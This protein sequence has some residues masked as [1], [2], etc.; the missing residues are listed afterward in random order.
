MRSMSWILRFSVFRMK[1][2]ARW[3][4]LSRTKEHTMVLSGSV[5]DCAT[6]NHPHGGFRP[7]PF[8]NNW[9]KSFLHLSSTISDKSTHFTSP[10]QLTAHL[11]FHMIPARLLVYRSNTGPY[12][13][14]RKFFE[15]LSP[16]NSSFLSLKK[17][18][19]TIYSIYWYIKVLHA[20][21]HKLVFNMYSNLQGCVV[22]NL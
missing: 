2:D 8:Y 3:F 14:L 17:F 15:V 22:Y 5:T 20:V 9:P 19:F 11:I 4:S 13:A 21:I 10:L 7:H 18:F 12:C 1:G 6:A 16:Q